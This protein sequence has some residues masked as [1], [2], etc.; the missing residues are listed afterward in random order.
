MQNANRN[1]TIRCHATE[2]HHQE[3]FAF[4]AVFEAQWKQGLIEARVD[5]T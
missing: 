2:I 4:V 3:Q 1:I 5:S